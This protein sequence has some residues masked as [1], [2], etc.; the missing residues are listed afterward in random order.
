[1]R[2][3]DAKCRKDNFKAKISLSTTTTTPATT[4]TTPATVTLSSY[5][6]AQPRS[7][8]YIA[9]VSPC[10]RRGLHRPGSISRQKRPGGSKRSGKGG[11]ERAWE[12][13][14]SAAS[15]LLHA[16]HCRWCFWCGTLGEFEWIKRRCVREEGWNICGHG[17]RSRDWV[18]FWGLTLLLLPGNTKYVYSKIYV[19]IYYV[20]RIQFY[21]L[22]VGRFAILFIVLCYVTAFLLCPW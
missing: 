20:R 11:G 6:C 8:V 5:P 7:C 1:M 17:M 19:R 3:F 14:G 13:L 4:T 21:C 16:R 22:F 2:W 12:G 9:V 18:R 10:F 15:F